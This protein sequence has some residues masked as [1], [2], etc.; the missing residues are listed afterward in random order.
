M[1]HVLF[2]ASQWFTACSIHLSVVVI[3]LIFFYESA[4]FFSFS[5]FFGLSWKRVLEQCSSHPWQLPLLHKQCKFIFSYLR[6]LVSP[7][8]S[9]CVW[10]P[11]HVWS[12]QQPL[13][14]WQCPT[15]A[16]PG[17]I[18]T[19]NTQASQSEHHKTSHSNVS[20][21][22]QKRA[23]ERQSL[24]KNNHLLWHIIDSNTTKYSSQTLVVMSW[25]FRNRGWRSIWN[26]STT[27]IILHNNV[28]LLLI[29]FQSN[30]KK[31]T[32]FVTF[33]PETLTQIVPLLSLPH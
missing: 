31:L 33:N 2:T 26:I 22:Q 13:K 17:L 20:Q 8:S 15:T 25:K 5:F 11:E 9:S 19:V 30:N 10:V 7:S 6:P 32:S 27:N 3:L 18:V 12:D 28:S 24:H 29:S 16:A 21:Q 1:S 14:C 4:I 23:M